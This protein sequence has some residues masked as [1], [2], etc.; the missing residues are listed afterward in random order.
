VLFKDLREV[1]SI[2]DGRIPGNRRLIV[3]MKRGVEGV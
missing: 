3:K 1:K 2:L